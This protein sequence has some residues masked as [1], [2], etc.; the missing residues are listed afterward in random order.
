M[1]N[2]DSNAYE[3]FVRLLSSHEGRLKAFLRSFLPRW[4]DVE[5]AVQETSLVAWKK[6]S[7]FDPSTDF[8]AWLLTIGRFEALKLRRAVFG[9][10]LVFRE[11]VWEA[12]LD[13][14][15]AEAE[16]LEGERRALEGCLQK[17][18]VEQREWLAAAYQPGAKV[19]EVAQHSGR[20]PVA[21]YKV[22]QRLRGLLLECIQRQIQSESIV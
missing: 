21:F 6:F 14:G 8:G 9:E 1:T 20:S 16:R 13:E 10:R 12:V 5:E 3:Q 2:P 15:L 18:S 4:E 17:L 7:Q 19:H 22:L 11:E